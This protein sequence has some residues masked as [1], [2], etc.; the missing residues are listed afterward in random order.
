[1][2]CFIMNLI[3]RYPVLAVNEDSIQKAY[4]IIKGSYQSAESC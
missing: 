4:E 1:M 3:H 2:K